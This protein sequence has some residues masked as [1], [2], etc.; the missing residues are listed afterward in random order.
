[1]NLLPLIL[2]LSWW[3][4]NHLDLRMRI[5]QKIMEVEAPIPHVDSVENCVVQHGERTTPIRIYRPSQETHLPTILFIHGGAWVAGNLDTH[6]NL[7]RYLCKEAHVV[8]VSVDYL[9]APEGKFPLQFEQSYDVM[10][11]LKCL[12]VDSTSLIVFGDS[13]GG[14]MAAALCM[15]AR[16]RNGP[17]IALQVLINPATDLRCNGTLERQ[18]DALDNARWQAVQ[19]L[20]DPLEAHHP[21]VSPLAAE[22][23]SR[24]PKAVILLAELDDLRK[25]GQE[26]ADKLKASGV[27]AFVYCQKGIGHLAGD[28]ARASLRARESL[29]KAIEAIT[30]LLSMH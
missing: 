20:S 21:Y 1:M 26:Y 22:D 12:S 9:N 11:W 17:E 16:D 30:S 15:M 23:L 25:E 2:A 24:L 5:N 6:D 14:N 29:D 27:E 7:A 13:A 4:M 3:D 8:V 28:G 10:N 18:N 19:Y